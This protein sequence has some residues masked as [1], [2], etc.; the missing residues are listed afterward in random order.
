MIKKK[1]NKMKERL[2]KK[3]KKKNNDNT[4]FKKLRPLQTIISA[5]ISKSKNKK[6]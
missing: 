6:N 1:K 3:K 4:S 5:T 2:V